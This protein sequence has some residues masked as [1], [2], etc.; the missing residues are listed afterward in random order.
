MLSGGLWQRRLRELRT[1][2]RSVHRA[3]ARSSLSNGRRFIPAL[4]VAGTSYAPQ[5]GDF[6][7]ARLGA[8]GSADKTFGDNGQTR[9][10]FGSNSDDYVEA[11][12]LQADRRIVVAGYTTAVNGGPS[13]FAVARYL[14]PAPV[15]C[16]V[17]NVRGKKLAL[18]RSAITK[19]HCSVGEVR[20][21]AS[22][23]IRRGR[24]ISQRPSAGTRL[25]NLGKVNLVVSRGPR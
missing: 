23:K 8:N 15:T 14:N 12:V 13:D 20:R 22:K 3:P 17:P 10:D 24:V 9:A 25:R 2:A 6:L 5:G 11:A 4:I 16:R 18:A 1:V 7:L 21:R 19:A